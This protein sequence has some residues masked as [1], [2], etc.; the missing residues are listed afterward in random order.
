MHIPVPHTMLY[1]LLFFDQ[2]GVI[3]L[4]WLSWHVS[5]RSLRFPHCEARD[6]WPVQKLFNML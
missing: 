6:D 3:R 4:L 2:C 1:L 5:R